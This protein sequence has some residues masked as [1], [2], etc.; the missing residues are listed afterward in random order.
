[1][2]DFETYRGLSS[3]PVSRQTATSAT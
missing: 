3:A 1:V 2:F